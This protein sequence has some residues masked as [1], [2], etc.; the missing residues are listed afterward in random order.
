LIIDP[1]NEDVAIDQDGELM[2][3]VRY[4]PINDDGVPPTLDELRQGVIIGYV[5][6]NAI[7][8]DA[9]NDWDVLR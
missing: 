9:S 4:L 2:S 8:Y 1:G 5:R 7:G 6:P 3:A